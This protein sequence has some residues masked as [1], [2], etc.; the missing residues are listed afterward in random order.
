LKD[1]GIE[2]KGLKILG[3]RR[4]R[5]IGFKIKF[6]P[7]ALQFYNINCGYYV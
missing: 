3:E 1:K 2:Y 4:W 5:E 6:F 7:H